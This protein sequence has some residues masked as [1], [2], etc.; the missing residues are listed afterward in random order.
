MFDVSPVILPTE[1]SEGKEQ[2]Q[3]DEAA[4]PLNRM[5]VGIDGGSQ[6]PSRS[7][8]WLQSL[9]GSIIPAFVV[10]A[11]APTKNGR[12]P[13]CRSAEIEA[14]RLAALMRPIPSVP[15]RHTLSRP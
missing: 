15:T 11:V 9:S 3:A 1:A 8:I 13:F 14:R 6:R 4:R 10:P 5:R 12:R 2:L 7:A